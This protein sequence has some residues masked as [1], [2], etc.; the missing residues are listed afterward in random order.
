MLAS[1][2]LVC[3]CLI[4]GGNEV[5]TLFVQV[6]P[7]QAQA[8]EWRRSSGER[9]AVVLIQGLLIRPFGKKAVESPELRDWQKPDSLLVRRL[10]A[11][12]D[13]YAFAYGQNVP[14][15]QVAEQPALRDGVRRLRDMGYREVV[16]V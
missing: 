7:H 12:A 13:V 6:T 8:G 1:L 15:D 5:Q 9:R 16:L 11:E 14:V 2:A 4:G 10:A 3:A